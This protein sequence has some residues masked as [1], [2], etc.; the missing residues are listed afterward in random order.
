MQQLFSRH[1][2]VSHHYVQRMKRNWK[3]T[4]LQNAVQCNLAMPRTET[5]KR[6]PFEPPNPGPK[7]RILLISYLFPPAGG[8]GVQRALSLARYLPQCGFEV[9]VLSAANAAAPVRDPALCQRIPE[10]VKQHHAFTPE[11]PFW[12][13][14]TIWNYLSRDTSATKGVRQ[15]QNT[16]AVFSDQQRSAGVKSFATRAIRRILSP[17]PEVLWAPFAIRRAKQVVRK[18]GIDVVMVTAPPFSS[19]LVGNALKRSFPSLKY[20]AD[21]RDEWISFY[22]KD[23]EFQSSD[24]T[25]QKAIAIERQT[26]ESADLVVAVAQT[27]L[28]EIKSRYPDQPASKFA[29]IAN[30]FDPEAFSGLVPRRNQ[31]KKLIVTHVGTAYKTASPQY[32]LDAVDALSE[33][34]RSQIETRFVGRIT[35]AER[36]QFEG[37]KSNNQLLGFMP[38]HQ[39]L[40]YMEETDCLLLTMTNNISLPG[41]LYEYLAARKPIIALSPIGG[42]VDTFLKATGAGWC[43]DYRDQDAIQRLLRD[44]CRQKHAQGELLY[45]GPGD[46]TVEQYARPHLVKKYASIISRLL[47]PL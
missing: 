13:R 29:C 34:L 30:G 6:P 28:Q 38:Q 20:V 32:Y 9:H 41:K 26:I 21:F 24:Y 12:V 16:N 43:V 5:T 45:F 11:I 27:S 14:H 15:A 40:R 17:E 7:L 36:Q 18:H 39:A 10:K 35:A 3:H 44:L 19:F 23:F 2:S 33:E 42:E 47:I 22:L 1:Y 37:R 25:R 31:E 8:I 46:N 4:C